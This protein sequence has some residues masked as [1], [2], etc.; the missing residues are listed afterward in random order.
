MR[1]VWKW[2][3]SAEDGPQI[4]NMPQHATVVHVAVQSGELTLWAESSIHD[5]LLY[6]RLFEVHGTG[7]P[8]IADGEEFRGTVMMGSLVWHVYE[9]VKTS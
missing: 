2:A 1:Q 3:L 4:L 5:T 9:H 7:H 6:E 8:T